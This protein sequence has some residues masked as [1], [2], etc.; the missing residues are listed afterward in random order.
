MAH[1]LEPQEQ[2]HQAATICKIIK[3]DDARI[4]WAQ[5]AEAIDQKIRAFQDWPGTFS[6]IERSDKTEMRLKIIDAKPSVIILAEQPGSIIID[7]GRLLVATGSGALELLEVQPEGK[8]TM[9][10][11]AFMQGQPELSQWKFAN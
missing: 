2:D 8:K 10:A 3:R 6:V 11:V 1:D 4:D 5:T 9:T 7:V